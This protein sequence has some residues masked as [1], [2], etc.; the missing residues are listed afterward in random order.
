LLG[1]EYLTYVGLLAVVIG[2]PPIS[3]KTYRTLRRYQFD[4]NALMFFASIGAVALQDYP[5]AAA[6]VFL[7]SLSEW[8]EVR[9]TSRARRALSAIVQLRPD[10]ANLVHPFTKELIVVAATSVPVGALVSVKPGDK[11]PCDGVVV[12][13]TSSIDESSLTGESRPV[14]K[15]EGDAVSGGTVNSGLAALMVRTTCTSDNSAV[16]RLIRL[17][18]EAQVNRSET[19][20]LVDEFAKFYTPVIVLAAIFMVSIPW[21]FG[22]EMGR[23]WTNNGLVLIVVACPCALIISTPVS[24][25]AGLAATAQKGVLI[26]GGAHLEALGLVKRICFDKT[27]TLTQGNFALMHLQVTNDN[28]SREQVWQHLSLMEERSSHPLAHAL[29]KAAANEKVS[30]PR[31]KVVQKHVI[32][33]GEGIVGVVDDLDVCVGNER[34][35]ARLG[36]LDS[37]SASEKAL[38]ESWKQVGGTVG[39]MS[40]GELGIVCAFC[41]ADSVRPEAIEV[42][43]K[44]KK[45]GVKTIMLTGDNRQAALAIGRQIGLDEDDVLSSLLPEDKLREVAQFS[46]IATRVSVIRNPCSSRVLTMMVGD[47]V[48]DGPALATA[49]VGVAMGQGAALAMETADVTLLD[50]N[51]LKLEY[52]MNMG[53]RVLAKIKQNIVFSMTTKLIVLG[54]AIAGRTNLWAAIA[55]DVGAMLLVTL[56]SMLLLPGR[57]RGSDVKALKVDIESGAAS[58]SHSH[59]HQGGAKSSSNSTCKKGCCGTPSFTGST[60][61]GSGDKLPTTSTCKK[62]CC[63][64][65]TAPPKEVPAASCKKGCC[66]SSKA[67]AP[68][69]IPSKVASSGCKKGCC[70]GDKASPPPP[71]A[72][73]ESNA[74]ASAA[75][76]KG[77]CDKSVAAPTTSKEPMTTAKPKSAHHGKGCCAVVPQVSEPHPSTHASVAKHWLM[78]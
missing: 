46:G 39:F 18:E 65:T 5:E 20:K 49:D 50:S 67:P 71:P 26:K 8:L 45:S 55:T 69:V 61:S 1:R 64:G 36:L 68:L 22:T 27:G 42:I 34:M 73:A 58:H 30:I 52:A 75:C 51:L 9:A 57:Q 43:Q 4:T 54:F 7:F 40:V 78:N 35:F 19:E 59:S 23:L 53:R 72:A 38:V 44:L 16:A 56:N 48:N 2:I 6:L 31:D 76:K 60:P 63:G 62:G 29:L 13:G 77:C 28:F 47:G 24:Y 11:V 37:L 21:A 17:V 70:G 32:V 74:T 15:G 66:D 14:R 3:I 10:K 33:E 12:E 41:A 25:V